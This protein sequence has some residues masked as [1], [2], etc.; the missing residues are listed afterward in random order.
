MTAGMNEQLDDTVVESLITFG[1]YVRRWECVSMAR[2][3]TRLWWTQLKH[4]RF[5]NPSVDN[6]NHRRAIY[7]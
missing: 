7:L 2:V 6:N 5:C 1:K 4:K 3:F